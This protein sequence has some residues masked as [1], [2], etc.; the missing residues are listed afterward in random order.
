LSVAGKLGERLASGDETA[1]E[2][3]AS[4]V[5]PIVRERDEGDGVEVIMQIMLGMLP[6]AVF[7][8]MADRQLTRLRE[9]AD[10]PLHK[11]GRD[12]TEAASI[13]LILRPKTSGG[14]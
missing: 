2:D 5:R 3:I 1:L 6:P 10:S 13:R 8:A 12:Q 4:V 7:D 14:D 11:I 9:L